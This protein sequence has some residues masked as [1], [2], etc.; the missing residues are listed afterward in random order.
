[1]GVGDEPL[2]EPPRD[3]RTTIDPGAG[4]LVLWFDRHTRLVCLA[5]SLSALV[6]L[7]LCTGHGLAPLHF[8]AS[9]WTQSKKS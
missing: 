5:A 2:Q 3:A 6:N 1:M 9:S 8:P 7:A 4:P